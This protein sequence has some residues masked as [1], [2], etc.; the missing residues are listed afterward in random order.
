MHR[1]RVQVD[2]DLRALHDLGQEEMRQ[3]RGER[4]VGRAGKRAIE[5][6]PVGQIARAADKAVGIDHRG[7]QSRVPQM[8]PGCQRAQHTA[9]DLDAVQLI[10]V[11][12]RGHEHRRARTA[13]RAEH[14][15]AASRVRGWR[16]SKPAGRRDVR[17]PSATGSPPLERRLQI[18][19]PH[20]QLSS[21][22]RECCAHRIQ[23]LSSAQIAIES[24]ASGLA[25]AS[26]FF[27]V[28]AHA[29]RRAP[30]AR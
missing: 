28:A 26:L 6:A 19:P 10:A 23:S 7:T 18:G 11:N 8:L 1:G 30:R 16:A 15:P 2:A 12:G 27:T 14:G 3:P 24:S 29:R 25:S 22:C 21:S 9:N 20:F 13:G 4:P 5:I 17:V